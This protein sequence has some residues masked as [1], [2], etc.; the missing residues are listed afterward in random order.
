MESSLGTSNPNVVRNTAED[1]VSLV[2]SKDGSKGVLQVIATTFFK[3]DAVKLKPNSPE[4]TREP[5][6]VASKNTSRV[7]TR[8]VVG[9]RLNVEVGDGNNSSGG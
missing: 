8:R 1:N 2:N 5:V 3:V 7:V 9:S 6:D 4:L